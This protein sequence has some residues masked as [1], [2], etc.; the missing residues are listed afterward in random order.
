MA[1]ELYY[2]SALKG[3]KPGTRGFCTVAHTAGMP[4]ATVRLLESLSSYKTA[5]AEHGGESA[6]NPVSISHLRAMIG[7]ETVSILSRIG[8]AGSDHTNR[9]NKFAHHL[10]L[11]KAERPPAGPA[12]LARQAIFKDEWDAPPK[13]IDEPVV[14]PTGDAPAAIAEAWG[15]LTGDPGWAGVLAHSFEAAPAKPVYVVFAAGCDPLPLLAEAVALLPVAKR[16]LVTF[17]TYFTQLPAGMACSWRCCLPTLPQLRDPRLAAGAL[18]V[19]LTQPLG[20]PPESHAVK[21]A[22]GEAQPLA[23]RSRVVRRGDDGDRPST[24]DFVAM[25]NRFREKLAMRP[26]IKKGKDT[27]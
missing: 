13:L 15:R 3:L 18:I 8:P 12:W 7:H 5:F 14:L 21:V 10:L 20:S 1:Q 26:E 4:P 23:P 16:W 9:D 25:D 17:N 19:D 11:N 6:L 22:R 24:T 27:P 2:T